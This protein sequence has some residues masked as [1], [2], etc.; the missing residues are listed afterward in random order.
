[1]RAV[2]PSKGKLL[3]DEAAAA[4]V[5]GKGYKIE[6]LTKKWSRYPWATHEAKL[7]EVAITDKHAR[8]ARLA[9]MVREYADFIEST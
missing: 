7:A 4:H 2:V 8:A 1:M 5:G 6:A 9:K 3:L